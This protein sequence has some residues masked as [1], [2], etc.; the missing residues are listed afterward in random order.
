MN[1]SPFRHRP[2]YYYSH[3]PTCGVN[4][5]AGTYNEDVEINEPNVTL[6]SA[7]G[8]GSTIIQLDLLMLTV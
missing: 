8:S 4:I 2:F 1:D 7:S 5:P 3:L 6:Q